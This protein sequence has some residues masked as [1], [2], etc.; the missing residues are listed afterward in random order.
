MYAFI[1][2]QTANK[3]VA[4][5]IANLLDELG[6]ATFLA[7]EDIQVSHEWRTTLL[8]ELGKADVFVALLSAGYYE[9]VWC[10][11]ESG[12]AAFRS[13]ITIIPLS[14]DGTLPQGFIAH[15]QSTKV[16]VQKLTLASLLPG[17]ARKSPEFV[18][19][20]LIENLE[21]SYSFRGAEAKFEL[22]LPFLPK[23]SDD[24]KVRILQV[25]VNN[26]QILSAEKCAK[27]YLPTLFKSHG[28]LLA[29]DDQE[30]MRKVLDAYARR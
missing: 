8:E 13:D 10:A 5:E 28:H 27:F 6:I 11:Q 17:L 3:T 14:L 21:E 29:Q 18:V 2:Y 23:A 25:A 20:R 15:L 1:S 7:H 26:G 12:I 16:D 30:R 22:L 4:G 24:Q 19:D 9:S